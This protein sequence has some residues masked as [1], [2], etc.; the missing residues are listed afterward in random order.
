MDWLIEQLSRHGPLFVFLNVFAEQVGL[1]VPALPTLVVAGAL[2]ADGHLSAPACLLAAV[3]G[4]VLADAAW[5][6]AGRRRGR[7]ILK[8]LCRVSLSPDS[9]VRQTESFYDRYGLPSLVLAKL[10]PGFSTVA[11]PLAGAMGAGWRVFLLFDTLGSLVWIGL[12]LGAGMIFHRA[13]DATL[14]ALESMGSWAG[15]VLAAALA[16]FVLYRLARRVAFYRT[17]R[18]LRITPAEL[19]AFSAA[20]SPL[21]VFDVRSDAD[22]RSD[23]R[24]IPGAVPLDPERLEAALA[25][26]REDM[27]V[28]LYCT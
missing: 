23:P 13:V 18:A 12:G 2:A 7:R 15:L 1:P 3:A 24:R 14:A 19:H 20:G 25:H 8:T 27:L 21:V 22:R 4:A 11:P 26:I 6:E 17:L 10:L 16:L 5:F 9:C 28:V